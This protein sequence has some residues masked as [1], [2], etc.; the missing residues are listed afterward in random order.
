[1]AGGYVVRGSNAQRR[2]RASIPLG[3]IV[4]P[5]SP[6]TDDDARN[7]LPDDGSWE[8]FGGVNTGL[9]PSTNASSLAVVTGVQTFSNSGSTYLTVT[10]KKFT[11]KVNANGKVK[12]KNCWFASSNSTLFQCTGGTDSQDIVVEDCMFKPQTPSLNAGIGIVG[13]HVTLRRCWF[14]NTEDTIRPQKTGG[15]DMAFYAYGCVSEKLAYWSPNPQRS[16]EDNASHSD[17]IQLNGGHN[18]W[19]VGCKLN[20]FYDT[21]IGNAN[22]PSVDDASAGTHISGNKYYPSMQSTSILMGTPLSYPLGDLHFQKCWIDGGAY[23]FNFPNGNVDGSIYIQNCIFGTN[24][25]ISGAR[26]RRYS[27]IASY[28]VVNGNTLTDGSPADQVGN[29]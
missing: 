22:E 8:P 9:M 11:D 24:Q 29:T 1:M 17:N 4:V 19:F 7:A 16:P 15:D 20:G 28:F 27:G 18:I 3:T 13:H 21:T 14:L 6:T 5:P 10:G 12:F 23:S 25:R 2:S 26:I